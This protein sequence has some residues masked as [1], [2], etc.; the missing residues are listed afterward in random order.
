MS[1][2]RIKDI[3][4]EQG[5]TSKWLATETGVTPATISNI[6]KGVHFPNKDLLFKIA[7]VL[8]VDVK[9]LFN[10]TKSTKE[11]VSP[12]FIESGGKYIKVGEIKNNL[13]NEG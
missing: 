4:A 10:S 2:L 7:E 12:I 1:E 6:N 8:D 13:L 3:L 5:K 9:E 11:D